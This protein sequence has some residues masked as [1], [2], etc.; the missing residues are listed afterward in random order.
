MKKNT[1][2]YLL[3]VI[4]LGIWGTIGYRIFSSMNP[5]QQE[6]ITIPLQ[7]FKPK[8]ILVRD[9]FSISE[10]YRDP[11]LGTLVTPKKEASSNRNLKPVNETPPQKDVRY[12]GLI[13]DGKTNKK[14]F[15]VT[16][17]GQ[18]YLMGFK[19]TIDGITLQSGNPTDVKI[20][21]SGRIRTITLQE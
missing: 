11:F 3:L 5:D 20:E 15:F 12:T 4:V 10:N 9:T 1:K 8:D 7:Q 2:T 16:I 21:E 18:Q 13:T 17:N 19:D 6:N 14:I